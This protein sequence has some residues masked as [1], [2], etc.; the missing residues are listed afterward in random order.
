MAKLKELD[1]GLLV[2]AVV[3]LFVIFSVAVRYVSEFSTNVLADQEKWGQFGDYFGGVLNPI[4]SFF[5]FIAILYTLRVQVSANEEGESRHDEQLREQRLFQLVGL[6]NENALS[7]KLRV[8][9]YVGSM[10]D[11]YATG[12]QAQHH[13]AMGLRDALSTRVRI[14]VQTREDDMEVFLSAE[15]VFKK[16]RRSNWPLVGLY[17]DSVFLVL[18]FILNEKSSD[19]F[20]AFSLKML[21]VQLSES[22]RLL[23]WYSSMFTAEYSVYLGALLLFGFVD[24]HDESLDDQIKPWR[25]KMI[26]CSAIWSHSELAK[27]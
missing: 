4:F 19:E 8:K 14:R 27:R 6:M 10:G 12:H 24:D 15:E 23:L 2:V 26:S 25:S 11:D 13:A 9:G 5:A 17:I 21:K 20:K 3:A 1:K 7:T 18:G 16:W 22:E